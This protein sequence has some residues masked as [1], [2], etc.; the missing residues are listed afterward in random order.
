MRLRESVNKQKEPLIIYKYQ[1][2]VLN[3]E[4]SKQEITALLDDGRKLSI[5]NT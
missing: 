1:P 3:L 4:C 2:R 5:P